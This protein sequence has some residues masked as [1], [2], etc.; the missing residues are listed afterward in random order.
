LAGNPLFHLALPKHYYF[1][2]PNR[3]FLS[4]YRFEEK[5]APV[6]F[7]RG[8]EIRELYQLVTGDCPIILFYGESGTGKSS[9]LE[10]GLLPRIKGD[11]CVVTVRRS[12]DYG[13]RGTLGEALARHCPNNGLSLREQWFAIETQ[14]AKPLLIILDQAEE[15]FTKPLA[16][17]SQREWEPLLGEL[18]LLFDNPSDTRRPEGKIILSFRKEYLPEIKKLVA[19]DYALPRRELFLEKLTRDGIVEAIEGL[20]KH[21]E[22]RQ[23][24]NLEIEPGLPGMIADDLLEDANSAISPVLQILLTRLWDEEQDKHYFT[25][26][27]YLEIKKKGIHLSDFLRDKLEA[28]SKEGFAEA[29]EK[30]LVLN[31]LYDHTTPMGT[32]NALKQEDIEDRYAGRQENLSDLLEKLV[33]H[34]LLFRRNDKDKDTKQTV[35]YYSLCHDTLAPVVLQ[36]FRSSERPGQ[37]ALRLLESK[38]HDIAQGTASFKDADDIAILEAGRP[39]MRAWSPREEDALNKGKEALAAQFARE[40]AMRQSNLDFALARINDAILHLDYEFAFQ[41]TRK[42]LGLNYGQAQLALLLEEMGFVF[43]ASGQSELAREAFQEL[44]GLELP[45]YAHLAAVLPEAL[46]SEGFYPLLNR[47]EEIE[48]GAAPLIRGRYL[49]EMIYVEGGSFMMGS[50][51]EI[52]ESPIHRVAIESYFMQ[53]TA[54]TFWQ[55][56]LYIQQFGL[57]INSPPW[58]RNGNMPAVFVSWFDAISYCNWRSKMEGLK[59]LYGWE[60]NN[61][62]S[63]QPEELTNGYRLPS[64]AE[65]EYAAYGGQHQQRFRYSGNDELGKVGWFQGNSD[66]R[67]QPVGSK[68]PNALGLY[69]MN[70]NVFEWCEDDAHGNYSG[71][72]CDGSAWIGNPRS[73]DRVYRGGS[74]GSDAEYCRVTK[75]N[76]NRANLRDYSVGFRLAFV[77][78]SG[79]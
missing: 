10:A 40:A 56:F 27:R 6:F 38:Q 55:Y 2:L 7:G 17:G 68:Q 63:W 49:G 8:R 5:H 30:G 26:E 75:R 4:I 22:T 78:Q 64:E 11:Y 9:L 65:W 36:S 37:R 20:T 60:I 13:L 70:G 47:L 32:A 46:G 66:N 62:S 25:R 50:D 71:G 79:D 74:W 15:A 35:T 72:P 16:Q 12:A 51:I 21:P 34:Y 42:A 29:V 18:K 69:D 24:Y 54:V 3:P 39:F 59:R 33:G 48:G 58:G 44:L 23:A 19:E 41:E 28:L 31:L 57:I 77:P 1:N 52:Y 14:Q 73:P 61:W 67:T 76:G 53:K 43:H 45:Q